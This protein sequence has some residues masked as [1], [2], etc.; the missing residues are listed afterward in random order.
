LRGFLAC[1]LSP[2]FEAPEPSVTFPYPSH[3]GIVV[4]LIK[5]TCA[6]PSHRS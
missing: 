5:C 2:A 4:D 3:L 1:C 6:V